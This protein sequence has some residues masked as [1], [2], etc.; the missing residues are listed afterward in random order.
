MS[1]L[2][3][4]SIFQVS[5]INHDDRN[6]DKDIYIFMKNA[7]NSMKNNVMMKNHELTFILIKNGLHQ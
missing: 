7:R 1:K 3:E 2:S 5:N 4:N 6:N